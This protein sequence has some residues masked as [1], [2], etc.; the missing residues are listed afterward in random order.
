MDIKFASNRAFLQHARPADFFLGCKRNLGVYAKATTTLSKHSYVLCYIC[1]RMNG[2]NA[3]CVVACRELN[4]AH[5]S[6]SDQYVR[7]SS[8]RMA[9]MC[10]LVLLSLFFFF[11]YFAEVGGIHAK[12][13]IFYQDSKTS[14]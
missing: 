4:I 11:V 13:P 14:K 3:P 6:G 8:G 2:I 9:S 12:L 7:F 10:L 5:S 1:E